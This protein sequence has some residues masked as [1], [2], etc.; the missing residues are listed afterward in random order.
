MRSTLPDL[1]AIEVF[2]KL[3]ELGSM[4]GAARALG[5]SQ[6]AV[7]Q[8]VASLERRFGVPLVDRTRRPVLLTAHGSAL[9]KLSRP[10]MEASNRMVLGV[11]DRR[12]IPRLRVGLIDSAGAIIGADLLS[13]LLEIGDDIV[14]RIG[15]S[16]QVKSE[17]KRGHLEA[18]V[19][20]DDDDDLPTDLERIEL[21]RERMLVILPKDWSGPLNSL[22]SMAAHSLLL[23]YSPNAAIGLQ[24]SRHLGRMRLD[25]A[26]S[27]EIDETATLFA[28]TARGLGWSIVS[29]LCVAQGRSQLSSL[30]CV[31]L[32]GPQIS[33]RISLIYDRARIGQVALP[34]AREVIGSLRRN[35]LPV[36][37]EISAFAE[38]TGTLQSVR[39]VD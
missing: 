22:R 5:M 34:I 16:S 25:L 1:R 33:R 28:T 15:T 12:R 29:P 8:S 18:V 13:V 6:S 38:L 10:V 24:V 21:L 27:V 20:V 36:A 37:A 7:S 19:A 31:P 39:E 3:A 23:R 4:T 30:L 17:L 11:T 14:C 35:L 9:L 32:P 26:R 2:Q